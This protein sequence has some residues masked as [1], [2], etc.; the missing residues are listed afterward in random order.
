MN[1]NAKVYIAA[2]NEAKAK[3][4]IQELKEE[5]DKEAIFLHLDLGDLKSIKSAAQE[6]AS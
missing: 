3:A 4:A 6:F 1:H 2:R 5:T